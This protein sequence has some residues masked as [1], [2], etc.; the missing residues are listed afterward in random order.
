M[1]LG[2]HIIQRAAQEVLHRKSGFA[3]E[4]FQEPV[5]PGGQVQR[6]GDLVSLHVADFLVHRTVPVSYQ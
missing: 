5:L 2:E 4:R 3:A 6:K 1:L